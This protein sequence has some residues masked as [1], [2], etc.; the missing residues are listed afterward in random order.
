LSAS[1]VVLLEFDTA[2]VGG[3]KKAGSQSS[4]PAFL[5]SAR[6]WQN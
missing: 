3:M 4:D 5:L 2:A 1:F 6:D